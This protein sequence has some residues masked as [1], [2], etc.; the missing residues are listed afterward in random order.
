M[1][2]SEY[3][4]QKIKQIR[5]DKNLTEKDFANFL[6]LPYETYILIEEGKY[7]ISPILFLQIA[8]QLHINFS[9]FNKDFE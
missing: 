4:S 1:R 3:V 2:Y 7:E 9:E 8:H 6:E 5:I